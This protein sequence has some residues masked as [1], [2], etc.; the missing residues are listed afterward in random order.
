MISL[1]SSHWSDIT[2]AYGMA[3]DIPLL[4]KALE[5]N[6]GPPAAAPA[7]APHAVR[8]SD[9][10]FHLWSCLCHHGD[11]YPASFAAVPHI[12]Q[13]GLRAAA[14]GPISC[15]F[16]LLPTRV[17]IAHAQAGRGPV[18]SETLM[19]SFRAA[20]AR[21]PEL[22]EACRAHAPWSDAMVRAA[23]AAT[24]TLGGHPRFAD[25]LLELDERTIQKLLR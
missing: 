18:V 16:I 14:A 23:C 6:P 12:V 1:D 20:I 25:A 2:H 10:W 7:G 17:E 3:S 4:L 11:I 19:E 9:T 13:I 5:K 15:N 22:V 21:L 8:R 24:A